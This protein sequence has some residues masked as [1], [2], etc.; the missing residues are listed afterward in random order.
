[1]SL[2]T[3]HL[4]ILAQLAAL[5]FSGKGEAFVESRFLTPLLECLGYE[6]HKDYEVIRH[7][8]DRS[9][10]KLNYP[11][12]E[13]GA[14]R[15]KTYEPDYAPTIRKKMFWIIEAKSPKSVPFPFETKYLVQGFQYCIHPEVQAQYL[16]VTNGSH[17]AVYDAHGSVFLGQDIY[18]PIF[19]FK[20]AEVV[21]RWDEIYDLLAAERIRTRIEAALKAMYDKLALS[22]LDKNY[23]GALLRAIGA[24]TG[25]HSR[26]IEKYQN[27]LYVEE[28]GRETAAWQAD[29]EKTPVDRVFQLMDF[30]IRPGRSQAHYFVEKSLA[31]DIA[32]QQIF[33]NLVQ[34]FD[35]QRIF[36]KEQTF[37]ALCDL[38]HRTK[39][40]TVK[41]LC[42]EFLDHHKEADLPLLTQVECALLR[43][44]RK[45]SVLSFYPP[46]KQKLAKELESAPEIIR[47]VR[48]PTALDAMYPVE[49]LQN[50]QM[51]EKIKRLSDAQLE[52]WLADL[53]K[54]ERSIE[55]DY[56]E[57]RSKLS[58][59]E[60]QMSGFESYGMG[61]KPYAFR[62]ILVHFGLD[63][64]EPLPSADSAS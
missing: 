18:E 9:S 54:T 36:R 63:V 16:L 46:L 48:P 30:P 42:R 10:F 27:K 25:E 51:F 14:Q 24:S 8:D 6:S 26:A 45:I 12:V 59:A 11:P 55:Q 21:Q 50:Q 44:T 22:S 56:R 23:P 35:R 28:M 17:S 7:G 53:L 3:N 58:G 31:A 37:V 2:G 4:Q 29:M 47:F 60:T 19:E 41:G 38:F 1:M 20:S 39:D 57:A 62:N 49:L 52:A 32:P 61:G 33:A 34:D 40:A 15:V 5:D 13:K 64:Q 43:I